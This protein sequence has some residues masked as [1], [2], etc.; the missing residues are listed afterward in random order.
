MDDNNLPM[1]LNVILVVL[2]V[3]VVA[4]MFFVVASA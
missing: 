3:A 1:T 2:W 4:V